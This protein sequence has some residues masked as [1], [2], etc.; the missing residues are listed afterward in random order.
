MDIKLRYEAGL[1]AGWERSKVA[2]TI[3][4]LPA[5]WNEFCSALQEWREN[6]L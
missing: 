4:M 5:S 3:E 6:N 1:F 2:A